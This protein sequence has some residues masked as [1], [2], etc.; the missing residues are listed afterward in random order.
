MKGR[1]TIKV[2]LIVLLSLC[3]CLGAVALW[4][5][6][7]ISAVIESFIYD[8]E[9][10]ALK[11]EKSKKEVDNYLEDNNLNKVTP[12]TPEQEKALQSGEISQEDAVKVMT[13]VISFEEAMSKNKN[14][15]GNEGNN[16]SKPQVQEKPSESKKPTE[17]KGQ[18]NDSENK[19]VPKQD[20]NIEDEKEVEQEPNYD[21]QISEKVAMLYVIKSN[22]TSTIESKRLALKADFLTLPKKERT[23]EKRAEIV[24]AHIAEGARMEKECDAQVDALISELKVL[25]EKSGRDMSLADSIMD[26]YKAEKKAL[27]SFMINK[28][29]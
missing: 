20:E 13:G 11:T 23:R 27:K 22:F 6:D 2:I 5:W 10:I 4:Q 24:T 25:L 1:K 19:E 8:D 18:V 3:L 12:L 7:N 28:Y 26:S 17:D 9:E 29:F 15:E 16:T 21:L 14:N